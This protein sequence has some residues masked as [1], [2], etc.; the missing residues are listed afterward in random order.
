MA[1]TEEPNKSDQ[2]NEQPAVIAAVV[3]FQ[4][5]RV[6]RDDAERE[7]RIV[8]E[9]QPTEKP[10]TIDEPAAT[11]ILAESANVVP[12]PAQ[13]QLIKPEP[14]EKAAVE[15]EPA[16]VVP[17]EATVI[18]SEQPLAVEE[19]DV[20]STEPAAVNTFEVL[21]APLAVVAPPEIVES[22]II[23]TTDLPEAAVFGPEQPAPQPEAVPMEEVPYEPTEEPVVLHAEP[24]EAATEPPLQEQTDPAVSIPQ[25]EVVVELGPPAVTDSIEHFEVFVTQLHDIEAPPEKLEAVHEKV[26]KITELTVIIREAK[27]LDAG[28]GVADI[29]EELVETFVDLF[30]LTGMNISEDHVRHMVQLWIARDVLAGKEFEAAEAE[31]FED[32]GMREVLQ[33]FMQGIAKLKELLESLHARLGKLVL[34][35]AAQPTQ[36]V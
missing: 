26:E 34:A 19:A 22:E 1:A 12:E 23:A 35:G 29:T 24:E 18:I 36:A 27:L 10:Y 21:E 7:E 13:E 33:Q 11:Q 5:P 20:R 6:L 31:L 9:V 3:D 2:K 4:R 32:K 25:P 14:A 16:T 30:E 8:L 15:I 28:E 17:S